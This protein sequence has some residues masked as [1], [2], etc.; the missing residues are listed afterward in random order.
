MVAGQAAAAV[1]RGM[2][3]VQPALGR[4]LS[5]LLP[6]EQVLLLG[7]VSSVYGL[8]HLLRNVLIQ[9]GPNLLTKRLL[10]RCIGQC[11]IHWSPPF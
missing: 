11:K 7:E 2:R 4:Q 9:P 8:L 5:V 6:P 3:G 10:L 1:L